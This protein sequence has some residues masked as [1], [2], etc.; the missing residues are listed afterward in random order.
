M[1]VVYGVVDGLMLPLP[2]RESAATY[3][4]SLAGFTGG[5]APQ[6][7]RYLSPY[8]TTPVESSSRT[9]LRNHQPTTAEPGRIMP[10]GEAP[11]P[12]QPAL[13]PLVES[14][15]PGLRVGD[16][17][18]AVAS[19]TFRLCVTN[20]TDNMIPFAKPS[21]YNASNWELLR[22]HFAAAAAAPFPSPAP[23]TTAEGMLC[24]ANP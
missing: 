7:E 5:S 23:D 12:Q 22:R 6:F 9:R 8:I 17:D 18:G 20:R 13:L 11:T 4:E 16:A 19:Y 10:F 14:I 21:N 24:G 15:P 3:N 2:G 1:R